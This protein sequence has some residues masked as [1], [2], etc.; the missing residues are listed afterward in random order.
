MLRK[1]RKYTKP[2]KLHD[3]IRVDEENLILKRYGLKN[4]REIWR[5]D[6]KAS[7]I[8]NQAKDL[9]TGG[10]EEQEKFTKK[11]VKEGFNVKK[12]Q[13]ILA[14]TKENILERRLQTILAKKRIARTSKG[15]RQLITHKHVMINKNVVNIPS[16]H[17]SLDEEGKIE[18]KLKNR[19]KKNEDKT[20]E[21]RKEESAEKEN[22]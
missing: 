9:I 6:A 2:K 1:R 19:E 7:K 12:I 5:A 20:K 16:Y 17:V 4:K 22:G 3:K 15:A 8:R 11:L 18:L 21:I 10:Q 14:L 13:D